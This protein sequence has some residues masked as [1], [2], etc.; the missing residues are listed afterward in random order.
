MP[1]FDVILITDEGSNLIERV[2]QAL[3]QAPPQR[4]AVQQ[5]SKGWSAAKTIELARA[6]RALT[7]RLGASL[8][9]NDR[10]DVALAVDADGVH[11]PEHG[12]PL[13]VARSL[14]GPQRW[15]GA[16]RHDLNG[17]FEAARHGADYATLSP[18]RAVPGK[19][20]P[21]GIDN[22]GRM[23]AMARLPVYALGGVRAA[24]VAELR[25]VGA[26]GVA[27]IREVLAA[28]N[29]AAALSG[30]LAEL[31]HGQPT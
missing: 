30:L 5:R 4:V 15:V 25:Q 1:T 17:L 10:V 21:L 13:E 11:L 19:G 3:S 28:D 2:E 14:V 20:Q 12:L 18:V 27:V 16:S 8:L 24:D 26:R 23:A 7:R 6:L 22:F 31:A 9:I 29:P